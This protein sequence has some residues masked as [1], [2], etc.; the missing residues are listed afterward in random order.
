MVARCVRDE[1]L[2]VLEIGSLFGIGLSMLYDCNRGFF[3]RIELT[4]LDPLDGYYDGNAPDVLLGIPVSEDTFWRNI[5]AADV[6]RDAIRLVKHLSTD[7]DA[8]SALSSSHFD[9]LVIDGDHSYAGV[10]AD[11]DN[12]QGLVER[13]GYVIFDDYGS[14]DWP[15]VQAFVDTEVAVRDDMTLVGASWRTAVFRVTSKG[16]VASRDD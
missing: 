10:K 5:D 7:D 1:K 14:K 4:A 13:G 8:L 9:V 6:P 12:Y 3:D 2:R 16:E 11:F 15:D